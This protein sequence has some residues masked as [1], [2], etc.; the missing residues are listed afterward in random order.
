MQSKDELGDRMK[1]Y[2]SVETAR[3]FDPKLPVYARIDGRGFSKFTRNMTRPFDRRMTVCMIET[4]RYLVDKTHAAA[5]YVQSDEI[6]LVWDGSD[7][8][9]RLFFDGKLQKSCSVLA[10]MSAARFAVAYA[11]Q[12]DQ[13]SQEYPHFDC[14]ILQ[15]PSRG[16]AVNMMLWRELDAR[17]NAVSMAAR[18]FFSHKE[19]HG[20][21][22]KEMTQ[23][24][25]DQGQAMH[26]YPV[27]FT[28]G[29][30]LKRVVEDRVLTEDEMQRIPAKHRPA[31]GT[32]FTRS[33]VEVVDMPPFVEVINREAVV[34]DH[35][36][37][38]TAAV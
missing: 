28:R 7:E 10:S 34:F 35:A 24:M 4:T 33:S 25:L 29:T 5:G 23:M 21:S 37:P 26:D 2:E 3:K 19:L 12:F 11:D 30:W 9:S 8:N 14:R 6:S 36:S 32:V 31:A 38:C 16:E 13:M 22:G 18:H 1:L 17:K 20:R 15:M 27:C